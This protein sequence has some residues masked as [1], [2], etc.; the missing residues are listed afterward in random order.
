MKQI[1]V[2]TFLY[3]ADSV[4]ILFFYPGDEGYMFLRDVG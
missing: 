2:A 4:F 3:Y 1:V